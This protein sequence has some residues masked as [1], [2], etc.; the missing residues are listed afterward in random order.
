MAPAKVIV[1]TFQLPDLSLEKQKEIFEVL[2]KHGIK[3]LDTARIYPGAEKLLGEHKA[4]DSFIIT[5]K[6][7]GFAAKAL[8][9]ESVLAGAKQSLEELGVDSVETYLLHAPDTETP[10]EETLEAI[11]ELYKAGKFKHFG[12]SNF[13]PEDVEK[14]HAITTEKGYIVPTVFQGNYSAFARHAEDSLVPTLRKLG[15][16]L[17]AYS[18]IAGGLLVKSAKEV[19]D[20]VGR[21]DPTTF[22]G[23]MYGKLYNKPT[24]LEGLQEWEDIS[25]SS[26][27]SKLGLA[28]RWVVYNSVLDGSKGDSVV[29]GAKSPEQLDQT[30]KI[31]EEG[32][33]P[34]D[35][36]SS[37]DKLW[38]KVKAEAPLDNYHY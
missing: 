20:G 25:K 35:V 30:L 26:G 9:K 3:R 4:G 5:T 14:I 28:Y 1:G 12:L 36:A 8:S 16:S 21:F 38:A 7:P 23:T 11:Q 17:D 37:I 32:P 2:K 13:K 34:A 24:I 6:A 33:L 19:T 10:I 27:I 29:I 15:I 18:P 31:I 22:I